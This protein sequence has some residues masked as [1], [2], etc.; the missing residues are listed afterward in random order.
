VWQQEE[1]RGQGGKQEQ[2]EENNRDEDNHE[3]D[4]HK[5]DSQDDEDN[6]KNDNQDGEDM[7]TPMPTQNPTEQPQ[8]HSPTN[9]LKAEEVGDGEDEKEKQDDE[10]SPTSPPTHERESGNPAEVREAAEKRVT[11]SPASPPTLRSTDALAS[12]PT[13]S[14]SPH[15]PGSENFG[16]N[17]TPQPTLPQSTPKLKPQP[18][19]T[20][21]HS[22]STSSLADDDEDAKSI[23]TTTPKTNLGAS[24]TPKKSGGPVQMIAFAVGKRAENKLRFCQ[25]AAHLLVFLVFAAALSIVVGGFWYIRTTKLKG[26]ALQPKEL[27][28]PTFDSFAMDEL[29]IGGG[30]NNAETDQGELED[31]MEV[32]FTSPKTL[33]VLEFTSSLYFF[34]WQGHLWVVERR[35][36][37]CAGR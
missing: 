29:A 9:K 1:G 11:P 14:R 22:P 10:H 21:A 20:A 7:P 8:T 17:P 28:L 24:T 26:S 15:T 36:R 37:Q 12:P 19:P 16:Q 32:L 2:R 34:C 33:R 31:A 30:P 4:N 3:D 35:R 13:S 23:G 27:A 6:H 5:N 25:I 18:S